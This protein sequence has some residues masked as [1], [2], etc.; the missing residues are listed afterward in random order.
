M[1]FK[2]EY[3]LLL[4]VHIK[5]DLIRLCFRTTEADA[6]KGIADSSQDQSCY[7]LYLISFYVYFLLPFAFN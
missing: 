6:I 3:V 1:V 5:V 7:G 2:C 4:F